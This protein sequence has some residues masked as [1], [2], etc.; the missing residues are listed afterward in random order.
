MLHFRPTGWS[1]HNQV[2]EVTSGELLPGE[3]MPLLKRRR[4]LTREEAIRLWRQKR[5]PGWHPCPP[6]GCPQPPVRLADQNRSHGASCRPQ[7]AR[8][9]RHQGPGVDALADGGGGEAHARPPRRRGG[10]GHVDRALRP[11]EPL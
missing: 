4:E 10:P 11:R 8:A 7:P 2:L 5:Q 6:S 1:R 9:A 3:A